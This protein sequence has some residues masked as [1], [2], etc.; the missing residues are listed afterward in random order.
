MAGWQNRT[1][2]VYSGVLPTIFAGSMSMTLPTGI[3]NQG[4]VQY[5]AHSTQIRNEAVMF[6]GT[7]YRWR[8]QED[9]VM[10]SAAVNDQGSYRVQLQ[11]RKEF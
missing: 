8:K 1:W 11:Y 9:S 5:T 7:Q 3:D 2:T 10:G 4:Q 6:A